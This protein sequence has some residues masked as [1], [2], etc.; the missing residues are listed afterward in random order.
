MELITSVLN[1][2]FGEIPQDD[3]SK[4][5]WGKITTLETDIISRDGFG[6]I[7]A[8]E[9]RVIT[10]DHNSLSKKIHTDLISGQY[11][12]PVQFK[13]NVQTQVK[14]NEMTLL[15]TGYEI[16]SKK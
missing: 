16:L 2:R 8:A 15:V 12:F 6:G 11:V 10:D 14:K 3:G 9:V 7:Q 1:V 13:L 4:M 5:L